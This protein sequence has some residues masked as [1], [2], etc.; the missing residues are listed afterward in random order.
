MNVTWA[1]GAAR[2]REFLSYRDLAAYLVPYVKELGFTHVELLPVTEH[3]LMPPG[4]TSVP[5]TLPPPAA[6]APP[7]T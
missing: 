4:V 1:P 3:P 2:G 7:T 6:S 5:A